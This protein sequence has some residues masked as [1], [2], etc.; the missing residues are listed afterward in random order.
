[1]VLRTI[2][3]GVYKPTYNWGAPHC[4]NQ[5]YSAC[6]LLAMYPNDISMVWRFTVRLSWAV[7]SRLITT[8]VFGKRPW[9]SP[10]WGRRNITKKQGNEMHAHWVS[11]GSGNHPN[12][13]SQLLDVTSIIS[14][15]CL[16]AANVLCFPSRS[17]MMIQIDEVSPI[18]T[19]INRHVT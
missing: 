19:N 17:G 9:L 3:M 4:N 8:S 15:F 13:S 12:Q 7:F 16:L 6:L 5:S 14:L 10:A 18:F 2:V 1:M 11:T